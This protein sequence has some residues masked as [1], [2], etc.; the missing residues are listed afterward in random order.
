MDVVLMQACHVNAAKLLTST[1]DGT[2]KIY[3]RYHYSL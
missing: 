2:D 1:V 3:R